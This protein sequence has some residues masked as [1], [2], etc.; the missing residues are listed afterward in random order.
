MNSA[1]RNYSAPKKECL[2]VVW[3]IFHLRPYL[4]QTR[5]TVRYDQVARRWLLSLKDPSGKLAHW[6]LRLAELDFEIQ[7]RL[8][9]K[10]SV[11]DGCSRVPTTGGDTAEVDDDIPCFVVC[12]PRLNVGV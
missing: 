7:Y 10:N 6:R 11:S 3:S 1:R 2:T 9:I 8:C 5:F 12:P 4:E